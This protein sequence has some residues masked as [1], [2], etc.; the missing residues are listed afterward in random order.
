[1]V[2]VVILLLDRFQYCCNDATDKCNFTKALDG[3]FE[4]YTLLAFNLWWIIGVGHI[5]QVG[6][7]AY[8]AN[9]I[10]FSSWLN[11]VA[12]VYT[13][14][15]WSASKDIIAIHELTGVSATLKSWYLLFLSSLVTMGTSSD[16]HGHVAE[17][18]KS[19]SSYGIVFGLISTVASLFWIL[20]HYRLIDFECLQVGGWIELSSSFV[21]ILLWIVGVSV[22]TQEG[23]IAATIG[24]TG[25]TDRRSEDL[26][27]DFG[28][29]CYVIWVDPPE[30]DA[31]K[32]DEPTISPSRIV[33]NTTIP[34]ASPSTSPTTLSSVTPSPSANLSLVTGGNDTVT[35]EGLVDSPP[36]MEN[37]TLIGN[38]EEE[39][40]VENSTALSG[41]NQTINADATNITDAVRGLQE[42]IDSETLSFP[43]DNM[44]E[45]PSPS[46]SSF[47]PSV[48]PT[49]M[50]SAFPSVAPS[51][52]DDRVACSAI[53][54][55]QIPGSNLYFSVWICFFA[56]FNVTLRWKAAQ[57]LTF[58]KAQHRKAAE[59][60]EVADGDQNNSDKDGDE[61]ENHKD[62][63]DNGDI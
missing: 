21:M 20:V 43:V 52:L 63:L 6:G 14:D 18:H 29:G 42:T 49:S 58:A 11:L 51:M 13:L 33:T 44:T 59:Q 46:P 36:M 4:G 1:V 15:Q 25:C 55:N 5:T 19:D 24:G 50:P 45:P 32:S 2:T 17:V 62:T 28:E 31:S 60:V 3:R 41:V 38:G 61:D 34:S 27:L 53:L 35:G 56:A 22:L 12:C 7:V 57:A 48:A 30:D 54:E 23:G 40:F 26:D 47:M 39:S 10:Y 8:S 37:T 16:M 9:N